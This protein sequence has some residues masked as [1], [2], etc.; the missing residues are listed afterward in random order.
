MTTITQHHQFDA[1]PRTIF[2]ALTDATTLCTWWTSAAES[3]PT[4]GGEFRLEFQHTP[5]AL[6]EG[7]QDMVQEGKYIECDVNTIQLP[8][9]VGPTATNVR[10][11]LNYEAGGTD[12]KLVHS[13]VPDDESTVTALTDG[14][15]F[16]LNNLARVLSGG[17][18]GRADAGIRTG[19]A[20]AGQ[21]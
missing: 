19:V 20:V 18:D 21:T 8:W 13:D 10:F 4:I 7:K 2:N 9:Q 16:F 1:P 6:A 3:D 5:E 12:L 17:T 11:V 14:W 15:N